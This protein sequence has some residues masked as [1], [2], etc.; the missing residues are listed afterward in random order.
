[1][2]LLFIPDSICH[3]A[4]PC[5]ADKWGSILHILPFPI[6]EFRNQCTKVPVIFRQENCEGVI[7]VSLRPNYY[8]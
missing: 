6:E 7:K 3:R 2:I 1:M 8:Q 4:S 5:F